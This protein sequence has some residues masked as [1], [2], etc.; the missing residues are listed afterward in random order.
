MI[1]PSKR[2][3]EEDVKATEARLGESFASLKQAVLD[4]PSEAAKPVTDVVKKHPYASVAAAAGTGF[5]AYRALSLLMPRT[6]VVTREITVQPELEIKEHK[7]RSLASDIFSQ[8]LAMATPYIT[9]YVQNEA[10]RL[11][12]GSK[13]GPPVDDVAEPPDII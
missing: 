3:T 8:A 7:K 4:I 11:L 2:V 13:Q 6:K 5:L 10:A 1:I 12:S 9:S